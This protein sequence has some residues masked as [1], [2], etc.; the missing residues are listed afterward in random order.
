MDNR[1]LFGIAFLALLL[2]VTIGLLIPPQKNLRAEEKFS[3]LLVIQN[4]AT[5]EWVSLDMNAPDWKEKLKA[6][7]TEQEYADWVAWE[8]RR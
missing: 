8:E 2:I 7:V 3:S 6:A 4:K 5:G 1:I